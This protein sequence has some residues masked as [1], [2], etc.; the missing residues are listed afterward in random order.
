MLLLH[1]VD[2]K[3]PSRSLPNLF[4]HDAKRRLMA[5]VPAEKQISKKILRSVPRPELHARLV[6]I[7]PLGR[8]R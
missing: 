5:M 4:S 6:A 8:V 2:L 7:G 1:R 3:A